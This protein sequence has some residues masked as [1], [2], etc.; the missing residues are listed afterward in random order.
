MK[1]LLI[2][3]VLLLSSL[4]YSTTTVTY[5]VSQEVG[6]AQDSTYKARK[7][8]IEDRKYALI[9]LCDK[10][11]NTYDFPKANIE[12]TRDKLKLKVRM[13][14]KEIQDV[15]YTDDKKFEGIK[16]KFDSLE[17]YFRTY[18]QKLREKENLRGR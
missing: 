1:R 8:W 10:L 17:S 3:G 5:K 9:S 18:P 12:S 13:Y 16:R 2:I 11:I 6:K 7:T 4:S 14:E 15:D